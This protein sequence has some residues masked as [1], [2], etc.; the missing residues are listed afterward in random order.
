MQTNYIPT[1][2]PPPFFSVPWRRLNSRLKFSATYKQARRL[3]SVLLPLASPS[4][5]GTA[6]PRRF[7]PRPRCNNAVPECLGPSGNLTPNAFHP[8][9]TPLSRLLQPH[10]PRFSEVHVTMAKQIF[11]IPILHGCAIF[12]VHMPY[13]AR[14]GDVLKLQKRLI[15]LCISLSSQASERK[16]VFAILTSV[17]VI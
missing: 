3:V 14:Y 17:R 7:V 10:H 11:F 6:G 16:W 13:H 5:P 8:S 2:C 1:S 12:L 9:W 4:P 15:P